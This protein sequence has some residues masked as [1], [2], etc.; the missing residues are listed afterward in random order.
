MTL[1][2][3]IK[4]CRKKDIKAQEE[5]YNRYKSILFPLCL[6]YTS[7]HAEAEDHLHDTF[8]EIF[9]NIKSFKGKG[10]FEGWM[11]RIA[12][13]KAIDKYKKKR[14]VDLPHEK[15]ISLTEETTVP[16]HEI[17]MD[18]GHLMDHIQKLPNQYRLIFCLYELDNFS[19]K[20]ISQMLGISIGTSK[21]NLHRAKLLLKQNILNKKSIT[22]IG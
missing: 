21:S 9:D 19:H 22:K 20:E 3:L 10:S 4:S 17:Q 5:L 1:N 11:K 8:I 16:Y 14:E 13:N 12:I 7:S 18:V 2:Q 15:S 6:K